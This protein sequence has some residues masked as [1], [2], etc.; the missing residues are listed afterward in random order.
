MDRHLADHADGLYTYALYLLGS[1]EAAAVA[2]RVARAAVERHLA[3]GGAP[4][5][6]RS[7]LYTAVHAEC[8]G[9]AVG[10]PEAE[11]PVDDGVGDGP[12]AVPGA[13][14]G[15]EG[16]GLP[17]WPEADGITG[18][19]RLVLELL[20]RHRL[21]PEEIAEVLGMGQ[22]PLLRLLIRAEC[23]LAR[24]RTAAMVARD[25]ECE[26]LLA[27]A[28]PAASVEDEPKRRSEMALHVDDCRACCAE[29]ERI[30][31]GEPWP[32]EGWP[33]E[34]WPGAATAGPAAAPDAV[35]G[36]GR[37]AGR[38]RH[39]ARGGDGGGAGGGDGA[40]GDGGGAD[41]GTA[42]TRGSGSG[43]DPGGD[44]VGGPDGGSRAGRPEL[45]H[46]PA[47][48]WRQ[49]TAAGA[50]GLRLPGLL[51]RRAAGGP[52]GG[53]AG[54]HAGSLHPPEAGRSA[55]NLL[56][57]AVFTAIPLLL[58]LC[59][60]AT[61]ARPEP[62]EGGDAQ[63]TPGLVSQA[64]IGPARRV[65]S[66][67]PVDGATRVLDDAAA[68]DAARSRGLE[69]A[70]GG[71]D[72]G[73]A[74]EREGTGSGD[75]AAHPSPSHSS[76]GRPSP[77]HGHP[78]DDGARVGRIESGCPPEQHAG[79]QAGGPG[80]SCPDGRQPGALASPRP[81]GPAAGPAADPWT[82]VPARPGAAHSGSPHPDAP[83][84]PA[85]P[86]P[87]H[88]AG[89]PPPVPPPAPPGGAPGARPGPGAHPD[90]AASPGPAALPRSAGAAPAGTTLT[91]AA[92][93][94]GR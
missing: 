53:R 79:S 10:A 76:A 59:H 32:G 54:R 60:A 50:V 75:G 83:R 4:E 13:A 77:G 78:G 73:D 94:P 62:S 26:K 24:H 42:G 48:A 25:G 21:R 33:G 49:A 92:P 46:C 82:G 3:R 16:G 36:D 28:A 19:R 70:Q 67:V 93:A 52:D 27:L 47:P 74:R 65:D 35:T 90:G 22:E 85:G 40:G 41:G 30:V 5:R 12:G 69:D 6:L 39:G 71:R 23:E 34:G 88:P 63:P 89:E 57:I 43:H 45:A 87:G 58:A 81:S 2:L 31:A 56:Q 17:P 37:T 20:H 1:P 44:G 14:P 18:E 84:L 9:P 66:A 29:A 64:P 7:A 91:M 11:G 72:G 86:G 80:A 15:G 8:G 61:P 51:P 68:R 38:A 55:Q